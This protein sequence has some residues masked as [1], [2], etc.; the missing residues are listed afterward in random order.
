MR[1][2]AR[3]RAALGAAAALGL[4]L[5][6]CTGGGSGTAPRPTSSGGGEIVV[7]SGLDV[8][9]SDGVRQQLIDAWNLTAEGREHPARLLELPGD[10]DEQRSQLLGSL[11][12]GS[13]DYDL[14]NLDVTWVPEFAQAGLITP[15]DGSVDLGAGSDFIP[16]VAGTA[17]WKKHVY[18]LPFNSDVG[19]LYY[20][21]DY[22]KAA[23]IDLGNY[24]SAGTDWQQLRNIIQELATTA[25][26]GY[27]QGW[28]TQLASYEGL[29]VNA[30]EA[31]ATAGVPL[32]DADG[33]YV[34]DPVSLSRGLDELHSRTAYALPAALSSKEPQSL[35]DFAAG[36]TAFL[37]HWPY[38]YRLLPQSL[39][40]AD[41]A[42]AP[43][44]GKAVLGGQ[45]LAVSAA[46]PRAAW[47]LKLAE[48]LT[49]QGS[50]RCLLDAGFAATRNS[51]Y[52]DSRVTCPLPHA[53]APPSASPSPGATT[54]EG[55]S[56]PTD[57]QH[58]PQYAAGTLLPALTSAVQRPRTP[59]YGAFTQALQSVVHRWLTGTGPQ[60]TDKVAAQLDTAL[61]RALSGK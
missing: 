26:K 16:S 30:V 4:L 51:A 47:A 58:R 45:D 28:T 50:E 6:A 25:P 10:A 57:D 32:T 42:V 52:D 36:R 23:G 14:V 17:M 27:E 53:S 7:A 48:F 5:T 37:R 55:S 34:A 39:P 59:Y 43:L 54:G 22:L 9:G 2:P 8:T 19:L 44:P 18:A 60:D 61:R 15:L 33:H 29:T 13:A 1:T 41:L 40:A 12:S 20:R 56:M 38:A 46:S 11:Q 31:F 21:P 35:N 49:D 3:L 24:P